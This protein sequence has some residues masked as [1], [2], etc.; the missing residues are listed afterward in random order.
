MKEKL[1]LYKIQFLNDDFLKELKQDSIPD[2]SKFIELSNDNNA[3]IEEIKS[4]EDN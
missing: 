3:K 1:D 4:E 2:Q